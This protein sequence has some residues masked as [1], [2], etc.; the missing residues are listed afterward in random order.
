MQNNLGK[1]V[2][3]KRQKMGLT[4]AQLAYKASIAQSAVSRIEAG[5]M[6]NPT[7][8]VLSSLATVLR[9]DIQTLLS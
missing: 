4:Q 7:L 6:N 8:S 3:I 5:E 9:C 2:S 1:N